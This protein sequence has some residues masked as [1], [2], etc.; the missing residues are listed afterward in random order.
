MIAINFNDPEAEK[1]L[2]IDKVK[3]FKPSYLEAILNWLSFKPML[4]V[5]CKKGLINYINMNFYDSFHDTPEETRSLV[6]LVPT[7]AMNK[8]LIK[9]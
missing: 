4:T 7:P 5:K 8:K 3:K 6:D 1:F 9:N 2:C